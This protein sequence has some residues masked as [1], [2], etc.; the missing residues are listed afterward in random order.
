MSRRRNWDSPNPS[1]ASECAPPLRPKGGG[2]HTPHGP[3]SAF[4]HQ[5]QSG[6]GLVRHCPAMDPISQKLAD[7]VKPVIIFDVCTLG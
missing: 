7:A 1:P 2:G 3:A 4:R 5:G 6:H